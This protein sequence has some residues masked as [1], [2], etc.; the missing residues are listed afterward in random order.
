MAIDSIQGLNPFIRPFEGV[1]VGESK[2]AKRSHQARAQKKGGAPPPD[3]WG[4]S[5]LNLNQKSNTSFLKEGALGEV[6][7]LYVRGGRAGCC[8]NFIA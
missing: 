3:D 5:Q 8:T 1:D 6:D 7:A 2:K 4:I